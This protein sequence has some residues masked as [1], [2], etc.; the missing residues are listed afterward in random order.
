MDIFTGILALRDHCLHALSSTARQSTEDGSWD[1]G[2]NLR[3][4]FCTEA[5]IA[6]I[7]GFRKRCKQTV[8]YPTAVVVRF[9]TWA[10]K[11][12]RGSDLFAFQVLP[13]NYFLLPHFFAV[14]ITS[15]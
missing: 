8:S 7:F 3:L 11:E 10:A 9:A 4:D 12:I 5:S 15:A 1:L 2:C 6:K 14:P 13:H